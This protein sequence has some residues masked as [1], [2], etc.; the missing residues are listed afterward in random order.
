MTNTNGKT[1]KKSKNKSGMCE[2]ATEKTASEMQEFA[3]G[4]SIR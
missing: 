4:V 2:V 1:N 3:I